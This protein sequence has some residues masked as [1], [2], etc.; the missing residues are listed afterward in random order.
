[1]AI[2]AQNIIQIC[3]CQENRSL[4]KSPLNDND[5]SPI[6]KLAGNHLTNQNKFLAI[7]TKVLQFATV[8]DGYL[9]PI[10]YINVA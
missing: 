4:E 8:T 6:F 5:D 2:C 3:R 9:G 10:V 1:M 7:R